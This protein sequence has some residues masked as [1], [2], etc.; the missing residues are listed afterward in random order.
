MADICQRWPDEDI[1][2]LN[3]QN[4]FVE[5][6]RRL[7]ELNKKDEYDLKKIIELFLR[8]DFKSIMKLVEDLYQPLTKFLGSKKAHCEDYCLTYY[9]NTII[10]SFKRTPFF[11]LSYF[12]DKISH[13]QKKFIN[14][15]FL[16]ILSESHKRKEVPNFFKPL[17]IIADEYNSIKND[18]I[19]SSFILDITFGNKFAFKNTKE[20]ATPSFP[21]DNIIVLH[22]RIDWLKIRK[23]IKDLVLNNIGLKG[24]DYK[25]YDY[26]ISNEKLGPFKFWKKR[27]KKYI[28]RNPLF[29]DINFW[30]KV[31]EFSEKFRKQS[32]FD[33]HID[34]KPSKNLGHL[35][36]DLKLF[37]LLASIIFNP[38]LINKVENNGEPN[39]K[40]MRILFLSPFSLSAESVTSFFG[41]YTPDPSI[42]SPD[43]IILPYYISA[44][45]RILSNLNSEISIISE[46]AKGEHKL[47]EIHLK[48]AII[49]IL[50][51]SY[52][53]NISA[54]SLSALKWWIEL[55]YKILAK[56]FYVDDKKGLT[57]SSLQPSRIKITQKI[58]KET[59]EKYYDALGLTDSTYNKEFYSLFDFL[60][61]NLAANSKEVMSKLFTFLESD[62]DICNNGKVS[63][64]SKS[65]YIDG[66]IPDCFQPRFPIPLDYALFPLFRFLRDKGAFWSGVT[67]DMA[68]GGESKTWYRILWEDF[69]N[70]P[71]YLGTIAK[72]EGI[73]KININ[74]ALKKDGR[75]ISGRF[76]A[77]DMSIINYEE[78]LS[79]YSSQKKDIIGKACRNE[80]E[81]KNILLNNKYTGYSF[82]RLGKHFKKF[83]QLLDK[84]ENTV[85]LPGGVVGEHAMFTIFENTLRNIKHYKNYKELN[86]IRKDGLDMWISIDQEDL[87]LPQEK[88]RE[89]KN[90]ELFKVSVWLGHKIELFPTKKIL[91]QN[92]TDKTLLPLFDKNG[93]PRM[94][95]NSQDKACAAMLFNN[96]F[97][98]V[99]SKT[100]NRDQI[101]YPW[102]HFATSID[103]KHFGIDKD[104][105]LN[106][107]SIL[108]KYYKGNESSKKKFIENYIQSL[109]KNEWGYLKRYFYLWKNADY[110]IVKNKL[111]LVGENIARFKFIIVSDEFNDEEERKQTIQKVREEGIIRLF[112]STDDFCVGRLIEQLE[113]KI[114]MNFSN[115][116]DKVLKIKNE[117]LKELYNIW[118]K[119]WLKYNTKFVAVISKD[120]FKSA[121]IID[122]QNKVEYL[123][124][125][126][127]NTLSDRIDKIFKIDIRLSHGGVDEKKSCNIR[128]HGTFWNKYFVNSPNKDP[129]DLFDEENSPYDPLKEYLLMDLVEVLATKI[130]IFD[131]R[132]HSRMP[133]NEHKRNVFETSLGIFV[134]EEKIETNKKAG[135]FKKQLNKIIEGKNVTP[136]ILVVHLSYIESLGYTENQMN[137]FIE[138]EL[139]CLIGNEN[140]IFVVTTGR[141]RDEWINGLKKEYRMK[142]IFKPVESLINAIES[143]ISYNDNFDVKYNLTKVIFGS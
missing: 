142:T 12:D 121:I 58:L 11:G 66:V 16:Y 57:L 43:K 99:E 140:F 71:L 39:L 72:S 4:L 83:R 76:V 78:E 127:G 32:N 122:E 95:G 18:K 6:E 107:E 3:C 79:K 61:F 67:R 81:K 65:Q 17:T 24:S 20:T 15:F 87:I 133:Q 126:G 112:Y 46:I 38:E 62:S 86:N 106:R 114:P 90:K 19:K 23:K 68:F 53:H 8:S 50:V 80:S 96:K 35:E 45:Y 5:F 92:V 84:E 120:G 36:Q 138:K 93:A 109:N 100:K 33:Q 2:F 73:T 131:N 52:A 14:N 105:P 108:R 129:W 102:I 119:N 21:T 42:L 136:H 48:T 137:M 31:S 74:I 22:I 130:F 139:S 117:R 9:S 116:E 91:W 94:G 82:I 59:T 34:L 135:L 88:R 101:Y 29:N 37:S 56:R 60:Q 70:N 143:G 89:D 85:F 115:V 111:D 25:F 1:Y 103:D 30:N 44:L 118:L 77:V 10:D 27:E 141:G 51:D 98:S 28:E 49:S 125:F 13:W 97:N 124:S 134:F 113:N 75:W 110:F 64:I 47:R 7:I 63:N 41:V 132:L 69:V 54:H 123:N 40:P 26:V 104:K 128:S 55:R